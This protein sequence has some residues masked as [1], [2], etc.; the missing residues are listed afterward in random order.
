MAQTWSPE[1]ADL[2][3]AHRLRSSRSSSISI[4]GKKFGEFMNALLEERL[5]HSEAFDRLE[6]IVGEYTTIACREMAE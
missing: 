4:N 1:I 3:R 6:S 2:N 5:D